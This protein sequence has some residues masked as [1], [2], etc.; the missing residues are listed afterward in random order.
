LFDVLNCPEGCNLGTASSHEKSFF[1]MNRIMDATRHNVVQGRE[2][3]YFEEVYR[4]YDKT[5]RLVDFQ[6][7]YR[8]KPSRAIPVSDAAVEEAFRQLGKMDAVSRSFDCG[9][10]GSDSCRDM[11]VRIAKKINSPDS[12]IMKA[13]VDMQEEHRRLLGWHESALSIQAIQSEITSIKELAE[14]IVGKLSEV[15]TAIGVYETTA[16]E[17]NKIASNIHMISLNASIEAAR[18]GEHGKSFSVV[19]EAI[20]NLAGDT[21][22]ATAKIAAAT[23]EAKNVV[24]DIGEMVVTIGGDIAKSHNN[25]RQIVDS[26]QKIL[27]A[28]SEQ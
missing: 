14:K 24:S 15:T 18:A 11:A 9:A 12:C 23:T 26:T 25:I 20:R 16:Q 28:D 10:C 4:T 6:R 7:R 2:R 13:H 17:I 21:Q 19:A 27:Q 5:L 22:K 1:A 3:E 8:T